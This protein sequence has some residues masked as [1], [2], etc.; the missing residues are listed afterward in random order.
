MVK[1]RLD[2]LLVNRGLF[3]SREQARAAILAGEVL[4]D[5]VPVDKPG[6][7]VR[8]DAELRLKGNRLPY[9]SRGGLKLEKA[10]KAFSINL[11]GKIVLDVGASTGGFTDCA[12]QHGAARV[13]AVD[14]GYGQLAWSL[15]QDPRVVVLERTNA[16]YLEPEMLPAPADL[17]TIDVAF[18]SVL[19]VLPAVCRCLRPQAEIIA[20]IKPQFEA[21]PARVGKKGVVRE[22]GT[23]RE[24]LKEVLTGACALDLKIKGLTYS[25][26]RGPQ[27][28]LEFLL[29]LGLEGAAIPVQE[30]LP[31]IERVVAAAHRELGAA[32]ARPARFDV[33]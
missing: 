27:G 16:R 21:G 5:E 3:A 24:V 23:H 25:P 1:Q 11:Q 30:W 2:L 12:L 26:I 22:A 4:V 7:V 28:N 10:L 14:V 17:A 29:W 31:V 6:A 8:E 15:R 9:V 33:P 19:K 18:I 32:G 20:L 13:Y